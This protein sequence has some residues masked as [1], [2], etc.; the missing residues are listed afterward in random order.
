MKN[1]LTIDVED[2]WSIFFRDCLNMP[3]SEPTEAVV[4]NTEWFLEIL[5]EYNVKATFFILGEVAEKF[6][7]LV[8]LIAKNEHEVGVHGFYH[9][10]VFKLSKD[11]FR[12]EVGDCKRLLEDIISGPV[13]GHRAA[14]FSIAPKTKWALEI[15]AEEGFKYDSSVYP[16]EGKRYGW[17]G[18]SKDICKIDL[19]SGRSIIEV[20]MSTITVLNKTFPVAG[21]GYIRHFPFIVTKFAIKH[22]EKNRPA[23]VYMH[24][25]EIETEYRPFSI[26][27]IATE[28][29]SRVLRHHR[30]QLRNRH[31]VSGKVNKLLSQFDFAPLKKVILENLKIVFE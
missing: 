5:A 4:K 6:P 28:D 15:L 10:Q 17:P 2:Y 20:P 12:C 21:G 8:K 29:K 27:N 30:L 9:K 7:S 25:Y 11:E 16:I 22:I 14:A 24:P 13:F 1:A 23:I 19:P 31:T 3:E 18:F 26:A